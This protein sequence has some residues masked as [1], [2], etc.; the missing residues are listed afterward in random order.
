[1]LAP[2]WPPRTVIARHARGEMDRV[3]SPTT[4]SSLIVLLWMARDESIPM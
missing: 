3:T 4:K 1:M 2:Q